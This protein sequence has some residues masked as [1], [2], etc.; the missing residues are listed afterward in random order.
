M[1]KIKKIVL[2]LVL[3]VTLVFGTLRGIS[4]FA[5]QS[6][7]TDKQR[8][9][10]AMLNYITVLTQDINS[11][12]NSR[13]YMEEAYSSLINNTFPNAVDNRTLEQLLGLLDTMENY[14]MISVKRDRLQ[15]IYEQSKARS[16]RAAIPNPISTLSLVEAMQSKV[17]NEAAQ[18]NPALIA[19]A[20]VYMAADAATGY[21]AYSSTAEENYLK[22]EWALNDEEANAIHDCRKGAFSY[23]VKMVNDYNLPGDVTLTEDTVT[24]F[25]K[26]KNSDNIASKIQFLESNQKTYQAYGGYWLV[27]ADCYYKNNDYQKC[28]D[29]V[30]TYEQMGIRIFRRDYDLAKVLSL[31]IS[32]ARETYST[33]EYV[34]YAYEKAQVI[35]DNTDN[36]SWAL[37]YFAA[38]TLVDL[39]TKTGNRV[40]LQKAYEIILDNVNY[41]VSEQQALNT[42]YQS[43]VKET[44]IPKGTAKDTKKKLEDYNKMLKET[45][46]TELP[47]VYEPLMLNCDLLFVVAEE[48]KI[49]DADKKKIDR[50]LHPN[51]NNLFLTK[52]LDDQYWF[53]QKDVVR[54]DDMVIDY[55]GDELSL[56]AEYLTQ[57]AEITVK[58]TEPNN[59]ESIQFTDWKIKRVERDKNQD[60]STFMA[61][62]ESKAAKK[63]SW[64]AGSDVTIEI[65]P[66]EDSERSYIFVYKTEDN[67]NAW[68]DHAKVWEGKVRFVQVQ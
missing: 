45:R 34:S 2:S 39:Y 21:L 17:P 24:E 36:D 22:E 42:A 15:F 67:K 61:N 53:E 62:Y 44:P 4:V 63:H 23:M 52:S 6:G 7:L 25:V 30:E 64:L 18:F 12:K 27:L 46:K 43:E 19:A 38:Q 33:K 29:A 68:Y 20:V 41:L 35:L 40:Y 8:N 14:R 37:R 16:I 31:A 57:D 54:A 56:P 58:V 59:T 26:Y 66:I 60:L 55:E 65:K 13:V 51:D 32:A 5:S 48:L 10:I 1:I 47:P 50:I 11:S 49:S 9:A 28:I 3:I